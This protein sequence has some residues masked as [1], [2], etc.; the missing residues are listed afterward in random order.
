MKLGERFAE[1]GLTGAFFWITQLLILYFWFGDISAKDWAS[2]MSKLDGIISPIPSALQ[3]SLAG[4]LSAL[5][6]IGIFT[7]GLL[8]DLFGSLFIL[9]EVEIFKKY[10]DENLSWLKNMADKHRGFIGNDFRRL[11]LRYGAVLRVRN[12]GKRNKSANVRQLLRAIKTLFIEIRFLGSYNRFQSFLL[13]F[14]LIGSGEA[15][16]DILLERVYLWRICRSISMAIVI[17]SIELILALGYSHSGYSPGALVWLGIY[18]FFL[19]VLWLL[20]NRVYSRMCA[21]LFSLAYI[22]FYK[23]A[24]G[25]IPENSRDSAIPQSPNNAL[26]RSVSEQTDTPTPPPLVN[27][28]HTPRNMKAR[29]RRRSH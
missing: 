20:S 1:Y 26:N 18:A 8:I 17:F 22:V 5:A 12:A 29:K 15:K 14:V 27:G 2:W 16:L 11:H 24:S 25:G 23:L 6:I 21:T 7:T 3:A 19:I 4:L 9:K 28:A 13:S 10:I